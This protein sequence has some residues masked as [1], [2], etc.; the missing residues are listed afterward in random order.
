MTTRFATLQAQPTRRLASSRSLGR[1]HRTLG[2]VLH[3]KS[4]NEGEEV[5][6]KFSTNGIKLNKGRCLDYE[7]LVT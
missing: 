6:S 1:V 2:V 7:F 5:N 3:E 4:L